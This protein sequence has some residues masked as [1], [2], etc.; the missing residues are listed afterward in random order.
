MKL[1]FKLLK[2][3]GLK[4]HEKVQLDHLHKLK[5]EIVED[6]Y[7]IKP[8]IVDINTNI[9]LDGHH[10][11]HI[12]RDLGLELMP[13]W[14]IDYQNNEIQV[15]AWEKGK[16][17]TKKDVLQAGLTGKLLKPKTSR[18]MLKIKRIKKVSLDKLF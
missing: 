17:I 1:I 7:L 11:F 6:G 16:N 3:D 14:L 2:I 5:K 4:P 9:I 13:V 12:I 18:H 8:I 10:R 15:T